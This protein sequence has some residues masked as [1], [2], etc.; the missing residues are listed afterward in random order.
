MKDKH[1]REMIDILFKRIDRRNEQRM[2]VEDEIL[3]ELQK[4]TTDLTLLFEKLGYMVRVRPEKREI[5][6]TCDKEAE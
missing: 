5:V 4:T 1:A 3:G 2:E 6:K